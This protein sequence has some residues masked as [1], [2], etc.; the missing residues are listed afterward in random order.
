MSLK[1]LAIRGAVWTIVGYG[2]SQAIRFASNLVLTRLLAPE[3]FG[4]M[5]IVNI[6]LIGLQLFSDVGIGL[7][8]VQNKRGEEPSFYNTAWTIQA[9]R[10]I[11]LWVVCCIIT[12]PIAN[13]YDNSQLL[14]LIPVVGLSTILDGF[15]SISP[16]LLERRLEVKAQ[17]SFRIGTQVIGTIAMFLIALVYPTVWALA[18]GGIISA[19]VRLI[20]SHRLIP[21][22][23]HR[24]TWDE[25]SL[26]EILTIGRW[27]F[28]STALTFSA[29]Q[30]DRLILG[31]LFPLDL[32]GIYQI[33]TTLS[34]LPR[35]VILA[36]SSRILFPV[37]S[38]QLHERSQED[39]AKTILKNRFF[40]VAGCLVGI[41]F[42][43]CFGDQ[44]FLFLY[45]EE[46][47]EV[48]TQG[49]WMLPILALG[50]WPRLLS[51]T[52]EPYLLAKGTVSYTASGN[53][54]RLLVTVVGIWV[55]YQMLGI[56]GAIIAVALNDLFY[57]LIV[58]YGLYKEGLNCI[59]Q[60]LI[61]SIALVALI[62]IVC[63]IRFSLGFGTP[64]DNM[65]T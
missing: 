10:G 43:S 60:D 20:W 54:V 59:V 49:A 12:Y 29:E 22:V 8:V 13:L 33:A 25:K 47:F 3:L 57:Y 5:G 30:A 32:F 7:N 6:F 63:F 27:V 36:L 65:F 58:A 2:G 15:S 38:R 48:Y 53:F 4:L 41:A 52:S 51:H 23:H 16:F 56:P 40:M 44:I 37:I 34:D 14:L 50:I 18:W 55:G 21:E 28:V 42:L 26:N 11:G 35:Q 45:P 64:I 19:I 62:L 17:I 1:K 39:V 24:L 61:A 31:K 9:I 46:E